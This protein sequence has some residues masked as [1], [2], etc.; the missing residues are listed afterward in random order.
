[1]AKSDP[2]IREVYLRSLRYRGYY[3]PRS[4]PYRIDPAT[5]MTKGRM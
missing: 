1:M 5:M 2:Q 3:P 4:Q